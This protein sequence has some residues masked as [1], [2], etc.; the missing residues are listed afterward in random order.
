MRIVFII[1][2]LL[3]QGCAAWP[4][5]GTGGFAEHNSLLLSLLDL[6]QQEAMGPEHGLRFE[7]IISKHQLD[8]LVLEG[9]ELCF[10]ASVEQARLR[11]QRIMRELKGGLEQDAANGL[12]VQQYFLAELENRLDA[13]TS[14]GACQVNF[15]GQLS[16]S[17]LQQSLLPLL[18]SN[19]QFE[20]DSSNL[21][22][23][24]QDQL[25]R[26]LPMVKQVPLDMLV[27]GHTDPVGNASHN[28]TLSLARASAVAEFLTDH[29]I[30]KQRIRVQGASSTRPYTKGNSVDDFHSSRRVTINLIEQYALGETHE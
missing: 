3:T 9:A 24:Y 19:N 18:N 23:A 13:V 25:Q 30:D 6:S 15:A 7:L 12:E 8:L 26:A 2:A 20:T 14:N 21:T 16:L 1:F 28:Q 27:T 29:G 11:E 10:P 5:Q 4:E 22:P 17:Q